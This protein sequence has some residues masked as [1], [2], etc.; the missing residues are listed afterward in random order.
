[1][2]TQKA[3]LCFALAGALVAASASAANYTDNFQ[4]GA[5]RNQWT[6]LGDACLTSSAALPPPTDGSPATSYTGIPI[7]NGSFQ[8]G[9]KYT[10][11]ADEQVGGQGAL[12]LTPPNGNQTGAILSAFPPFAMSQ[13]IQITF[14]TYTYGGDSGGLAKNGA[15][16]IVFFLTDAG[17]TTSPNPAPTTTGAE[18]GSM[19]YDCSNVNGVYDGVAN[20]YLGL[21][22]DEFGNFLNTGDNG[23]V[24][25]FN[26]SD[27][28]SPVYGL[29]P[30]NPG[31]RG[32]N[33]YY[34][35]NR[36]Q[37]QPE[38][39]GLRGAGNTNWAWLSTQN[40]GYYSGNA[41]YNRYNTSSSASFWTCKS[42]GTN[43]Q[44][45][46]GVVGAPI[47][48]CT[49]NTAGN[50]TGWSRATSNKVQN[51]C[52]SGQYVKTSN[53]Y[54]GTDGG[55]YQ[56]PTASSPITYN[57]NAIPGG[58]AVLPGAFAYDTNGNI[59]GYAAG[60]QPIANNSK[61]ATRNPT[62]STQAA[63]VA[64]PITYKLTISPQGLLNFAYSYNNGDFQPV[65]SNSPVTSY[66]GPIPASLRF[67]FSAGTGGNNNVHEITCFTAAPM[68]ANSSAGSNTITGKVTGNSQF[69][70]ASYSANNWW[71]SLVADPLVIQSDGTLAIGTAANWDAKC[72]LTGAS[73]C[74]SMTKTDSTT[75]AVTATYPVTKQATR[76]LLTS[77]AIGTTQGIP[78]AWTSLST[79]Q[80]NA[81]NVA[82]TNVLDTTPGQNRVAWLQGNQTVE[83]LYSGC[84]ST[85]T[86][87]PPC[88]MR[89]RTYVLGDIINSSPTFVGGPTSGAYPD[90]F[91]DQ[92]YPSAANPENA[93][94]S[95]AYSTFVS[96]NASRLNV[97]YVGG[98]DG[99]LH[100]FGAGYNGNG[101]FQATGN[102][103]TE[104]VGYMPYDVLLKK[105]VN[106]ADPLYKH[107]Y[108]VDA[109]PVAGDVFY[110]KAWHTWLVGG[111]GSNGQEIYALDVT[112][113]SNFVSGG[114]SNP[115][116]VIG[117][118]DNTTPSLSH[119]GNTV[120][121]PVIA[122]MHNG[123][124][125]IIFGSGLVNPCT[126][127]AP[128]TCPTSPTEGI[129]IGLID[130]GTGAVSFQF[131]DTG[132]LPT[133]V[134]GAPGGIAYVSQVDLDGDHVADYL[135]AGDT[136]GHVWRF[137]VTG[138]TVTQWQQY[139]TSRFLLFTATDA[140]GNPQPITTAIMPLA[141]Q[142]GLVTRA[143]LYFGTG[144]QTQPTTATGMQ[145]AKTA[146][147]FYGIWDWNMGAWNS[148]STVKY[149]SLA[150]G[151]ITRAGLLAQKVV[152]PPSD[153]T[154]RYLSNTGVVCWQGDAPTTQCPAENQ[155]GW[156]FDFPDR[157]QSTGQ[158]ANQGE[159]AIYNP[160]FIQGAV[161]VNTAIPPKILAA[162][163]NPNLQS[164]WTMAFDPATG[165]GFAN[166]FFADAGGGFGAGEATV[167]GTMV[168]GVGTPTSVQYGGKNY[169][170]TQT[171]TGGARLFPVNPPSGSNPSRVSWRELV[172]P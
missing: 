38:R 26:T 135:Y 113:P 85:A 16:G 165:D 18:G 94:G 53:T 49:S 9:Q 149:A 153:A 90:A 29:L 35:K 25:I 147:T 124:W 30:S 81:L 105:A 167:S 71:G 148:L 72:V 46:T 68:Q 129:Y 31:Y 14:T 79:V 172:N 57:Y 164:G 42:D 54:T 51:A 157:G 104:V 127:T 154:H 3:R 80:Q 100:G 108:L 136:Q 138:N 74:D 142:T 132:A 109:T 92:L 125:A 88:D 158:F 69:F 28:S 21:G 166:N 160:A 122:R 159:Q 39:I 112:N 145:Y 50:C 155:Y 134:N 58:Y 75:G 10:I 23:S 151:S 12:L 93:S 7:C 41:W 123:Q 120:G 66:N 36:P 144:Q 171:I 63:D 48:N 22:I 95:K 45:V 98:N 70:L 152:T 32:T 77:K 37:Y 15:D 2:S 110:N 59:T 128:A 67:G 4:Y 91:Y 137:D 121:T 1:M 133:G 44:W 60:S 114:K 103:G 161:L 73:P 89:A 119:L 168:S 111:V 19:G 61:S 99:F 17:T 24:G 5:T 84:S 116:T 126:A 78:L 33:S 34:D 170:V 82:T 131:L 47:W 143:M 87:T 146:Q 96:Q 162:Q 8:G 102:D 130:P 150:S 40:S 55:T 117:D 83:Q 169:V 65:L 13:G 6:P 107:D 118:W 76:T 141:V 140:S 52:R 27:P 115:A 64:W 139:I 97:V 163:C 20:G 62:A 101:G 11:P 106:L 156:M 86:A 43:C 56:V